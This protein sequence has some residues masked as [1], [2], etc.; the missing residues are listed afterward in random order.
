MDQAALLN[1]VQHLDDLIEVYGDVL[2]AWESRRPAESVIPVLAETGR[3]DASQALALLQQ[4]L[5][6]GGASLVAELE[7]V[8]EAAGE[9]GDPTALK[10]VDRVRQG[11][12]HT[13]RFNADV[14]ARSL[15]DLPDVTDLPSGRLGVLDA[16]RRDVRAFLKAVARLRPRQQGG[17]RPIRK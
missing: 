13:A 12:L 4:V 11:L 10:A 6:G 7:A 9:S 2:I 8:E 5:N 16:A 17:N 15:V 3:L 1:R 14:L